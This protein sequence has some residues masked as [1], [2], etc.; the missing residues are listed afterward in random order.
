[1]AAFSRYRVIPASEGEGSSEA[2]SPRDRAVRLE[3]LANLAHELRT[4]VQVLLG[5]IEILLDDLGAELSD[6]PRDMIER[7]SCNAHDLARTVENLMEFAIAGKNPQPQVEEA[8]EVK[9]LVE[10][11]MPALEAA[12]GKK[13]LD[14]RLALSESPKLVECARRPVR[15][16]LSNLASNAVKFTDS[17]CV[18]IAVTEGPTRNGLDSIV[19]EVTDTGPGMDLRH[20]KRAFESLHQL[21]ES[22]ARRFRG[23]GLG[24]AVVRR[25]VSTLGATLE[26]QTA[27]GKGCSFKVTI[28]CRVVKRARKASFH[29]VF[30]GAVR[31]AETPSGTGNRLKPAPRFPH[32]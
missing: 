6:R 17:G 8:F 10:E 16:I 7:M 1:M 23:L 2:T 18:T 30:R 25:N 4:P 5:Y 11:A 9:T 19:L 12:N 31:I 22:N 20:L 27:P 14:L 13:K 32:K 29:R 3:A 26:V 28:P 21:S 24:L 15:V